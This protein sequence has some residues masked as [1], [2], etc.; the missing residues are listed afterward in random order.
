MFN[1]FVL[2]FPRLTRLNLCS[3]EVLYTSEEDEYEDD[4]KDHHQE[5]AGSSLIAKSLR[6]DTQAMTRP[7]HSSLFLSQFLSSD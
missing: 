7:I 1:V 6:E 4:K 2:L 3:C 5:H